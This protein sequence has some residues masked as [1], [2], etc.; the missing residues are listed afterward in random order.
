MKSLTLEKQGSMSSAELK[1]QIHQYI[2]KVDDRLL[3]LILAM[4]EADTGS[5][6]RISIEQYNKELDEA[7]AE[8][9]KGKFFTQEEVEKMSKEW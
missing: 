4:I 8:I 7:E 2:D 5:A 3:N 6:G 1:A 9:D